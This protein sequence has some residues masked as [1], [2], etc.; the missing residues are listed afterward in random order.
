MGMKLNKANLK[1]KKIMCDGVG[2]M[3]VKPNVWKLYDG[4]RVLRVLTCDTK[5]VLEDFVDYNW[6]QMGKEV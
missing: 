6:V 1:V 4:I 5:A 3:Q 2:F